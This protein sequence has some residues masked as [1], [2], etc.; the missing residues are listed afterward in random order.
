MLM[1][2]NFASAPEPYILGTDISESVLHRARSGT[3]SQL[4]VNRGLP[5][6]SLVRHFEQDGR[7]W[8]VSPQI[9]RTVR[10][11]RLNL[12]E[13]WPALPAMDVILLRNVLIYFDDTTRGDVLNRAVAAL[14][15]GGYLLLGGAETQ[16]L[17]SDA[18][19][20]LTLGNTICFRARG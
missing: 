9:A 12:R 8:R 3:Y 19:Q 16:M 4:E 7:A 5:A 20:R 18:V 14:R 2:E 17:R 1:A 13:P 15:P 6:R 11:Q 10:F